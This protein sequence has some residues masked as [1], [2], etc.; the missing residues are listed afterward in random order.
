MAQVQDFNKMFDIDSSS[1]KSF[2]GPVENILGESYLC[3]SYLVGA[4]ELYEMVDIIG[5]LYDM[6]GISKV[7]EDNVI[8]TSCLK[9]T[10]EIRT[11]SVN[12]ITW[13]MPDMSRVVR[14][15]K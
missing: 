3:S 1:K 15:L 5:A 13:R 8:Q 9:K 12:M 10:S 7:G 14:P 11:K 2:K 6:E 4:I